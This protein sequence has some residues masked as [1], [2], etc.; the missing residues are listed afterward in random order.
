M[1]NETFTQEEIADFFSTEIKLKEIEPEILEEKQ[2]DE[3]VTEEPEVDEPV[4]VENWEFV[5]F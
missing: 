2:P 3:V 1:A 4:V 5:D